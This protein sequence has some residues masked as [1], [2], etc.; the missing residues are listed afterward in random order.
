MSTE[1][2]STQKV[3]S[4]P[5]R[6]QRWRHFH[7]VFLGRPIVVV[8]LVIIM[9]LFITAI[10]ASLLAP[11]DPND[12]DIINS[13]QKPSRAHLLGT[14]ALGQDILSRVIFGSRTSLFIGII[15]VG[16][17]ATIGMALGL[18]AGYFGGCHIG[19]DAS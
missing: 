2:V 8:G 9:A 5:H 1:L 10:L 12:Q 4:T 3:I 17:S 18:I 16:V 14:D 7:R 11:Y 15:V 19:H 6:F 13:L